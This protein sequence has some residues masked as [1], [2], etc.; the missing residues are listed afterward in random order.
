LHGDL[1][2]NSINKATDYRLNNICSI[3]STCRNVSLQPSHP[4]NIFG[5]KAFT[6]SDNCTL[7]SRGQ[8]GRRMQ[9]N[10][11]LHL[12]PKLWLY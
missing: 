1:C 10:I 7:V 4:E 3:S 9:T 12:I 11:Y 8:S 6:T 5:A 2:D